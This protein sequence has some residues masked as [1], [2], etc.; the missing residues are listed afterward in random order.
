MT[1]PVLLLAAGAALMAAP[2]DD[3][4]TARLEAWDKGLVALGGG[5]DN[6]ILHEASWSADGATFSC[7]WRTAESG[8][9]RRTVTWPEGRVADLPRG[10][11][12]PGPA[13]AGT[14]GRS[15]REPA[16]T[17]SVGTVGWKGPAGAGKLTVEGRQLRH[18]PE[19]GAP[20]VLAEAPEGKRWAGPPSWSG[21]ATRVALWLETLTNPRILRVPGVGDIPYPVAG[22]PLPDPRPFVVDLRTGAASTPPGSLLGP[23]H[24]MRLLDW[25][26]DGRLLSEYTL[27]GF[28]GHGILA[29]EPV[30]CGKLR[31]EEPGGPFYVDGTRHRHDLGDGT[32]LWA[33]E[34]TGFRHLERI[35]LATGRTL[36]RITDGPWVVSGVARVDVAAGLVW[37]EARGF[38]KGEN[39]HHAH[40]LRARLDGKEAPVDLTPG[41]AHHEVA[42]SPCGRWFLHTASRADLPPTHALRRLAD[43]AVVATLGTADD[44]RARA[45]GWGGRRVVRAKDRDGTHDIWGVVHFPH[46]FDPSKRHPVVEKIYA[47]PH[48][49]HVPHGYAPWWDADITDLTQS[50]F[51]VVQCD[52]RGTFGRGRAFQAQAFGDLADAGLPDRVAWIR[53]AGAR[54][55]QMDLARVG[56]FGASAGGQN[57]AWALLRHGD[58]YRAGVADCGCH[59]NRLDKVW[60]NEQWLGWPVGPA[61]DRSRCANEAHRL[62]G[63]LLLTVGESDSNV[64]PRCTYEL[65]EA[66]RA[67]GKSHLVSLEVIKG[68]GHGAGELPAPRV[69]RVD[70]FRTHLGGPR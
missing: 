15:W 33:T 22:D 49:A 41:D 48:G 23:V 29:H 27:R 66:F 28:T 67:A 69:L 55:P 59:D 20:R 58:F 8:L 21:D 64:D 6:A 5:I 45:K 18:H 36:A 53:A 26:A 34:R 57:T 24:T 56:I 7:L 3:A 16:A 4:V 46:P 68:A 43:G 9:V 38:H 42:F 50:G 14:L 47:G 19:K 12:Q 13:P 52:A 11:T 35:D 61:Y 65:A 2:A 60:W 37:L 10:A 17:L 44:A 40:L 54:I 39:P 62:A 51:F 31:A 32:A 63:P 30:G 1:F 70:F 25:T